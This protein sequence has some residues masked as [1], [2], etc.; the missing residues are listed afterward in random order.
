M[1]FCSLLIFFKMNFFKKFMKIPSRGMCNSLD[2][3]IDGRFSLIWVQT[4]C[5]SYQQTKLALRVNSYIKALY[6]IYL[7]DLD[8][9]SMLY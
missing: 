6:H 7:K 3:D 8:T 5:K 4:V 9:S 2:S 1:N